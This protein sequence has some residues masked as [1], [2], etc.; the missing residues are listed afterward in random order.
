MDDF[1]GFV[2]ISKINKEFDNYVSLVENFKISCYVSNEQGVLEETDKFAIMRVIRAKIQKYFLNQNAVLN[3]F[4]NVGV[5][6]RLLP[7]IIDTF[8]KL[9]NFSNN[10]EMTVFLNG[11]YD[12][13][14]LK[15]RKVKDGEY[16]IPDIRRTYEV[17]SDKDL[18]DAFSYFKNYFSHEDVN[19]FLVS[20]ADAIIGKKKILFRGGGNNGK[21]T[22]IRTLRKTFLGMFT[23]RHFYE[24]HRNTEKLRVVTCELHHEGINIDK[25]LNQNMGCSVIIA[26]NY[27]GPIKSRN[28]HAIVDFKYRFDDANEDYSC[29]KFN[30]V[31]NLI[32]TS[33]EMMFKPAKK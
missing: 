13:S 3:H 8:H 1:Y 2:E 24:L 7:E 25:I 19:S 20:V 18:E 6:R 15:F 22:V 9:D 31:F 28:T 33:S 23:Q 14:D 26:T 32:M 29:R 17:S 21:S 5:M 16:V 12:L 11:I 30:A 4:R 10:Y 27:M